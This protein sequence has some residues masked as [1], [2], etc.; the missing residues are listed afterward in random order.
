MRYLT[1]TL[2][3]GKDR[4]VNGWATFYVC[5][6]CMPGFMNRHFFQNMRYLFLLKEMNEIIMYKSL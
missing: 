4:A 5:S 2:R 1:G 3:S 6:F